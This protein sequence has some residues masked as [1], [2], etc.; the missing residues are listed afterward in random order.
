MKMSA[1]K[2]HKFDLLGNDKETSALMLVRLL[3]FMLAK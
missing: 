1:L 2:K 3:K